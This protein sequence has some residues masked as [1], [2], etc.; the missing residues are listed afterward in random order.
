MGRYRSR[1]YIEARRILKTVMETNPDFRQAANLL[2]A[3]EKEIIKD[4][5]VG[6][7]A[8]AAI[9]G[10]IAAVVVALAKK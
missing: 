7:G 3:A 4:G 5:L 2:E 10:A 8:G 6:V 1:Q 9:V